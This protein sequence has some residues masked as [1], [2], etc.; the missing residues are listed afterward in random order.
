MVSELEKLK[1][2]KQILKM[3]FLITKLKILKIR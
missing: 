3:I 2:L 1:D